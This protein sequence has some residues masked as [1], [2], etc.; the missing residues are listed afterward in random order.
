MRA[1]L[2]HAGEPHD[3]AILIVTTTAREAKRLAF[4]ELWSLI[5][6]E[7]LEV[8]VTWMKDADMPFLLQR[9]GPGVHSCMES[10]DRCE[11]WY[12][13]PLETDLHCAD[14]VAEVEAEKEELR[15]ELLQGLIALRDEKGRGEELDER[16]REYYADSGILQSFPA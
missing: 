13:Y 16:W 12:P 8:R 7:F 4:P 9:Y 11:R 10:C 1:Y 15:E 3:G 6:A 2:G 14:C 5:D